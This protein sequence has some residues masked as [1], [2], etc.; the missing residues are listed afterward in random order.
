MRP[1]QYAL[2]IP[3]AALATH[4]AAQSAPATTEV[5]QSTFGV[6]SGDAPNMQFTPTTKISRA[7]KPNY[8]WVIQVKTDKPS[9]HWREE[10]TLPAAATWGVE[11]GPT[12]V[13]KDRRTAV[14][15]RDVAPSEG[16]I[17]NSWAVA[18]GDPAGHYVIKVSVDGGP[19][20]RFDFDVE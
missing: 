14:T 9:V 19:E 17:L 15:E 7:A 12:R 18:D 1:L 5:L 16:L 20:Q 8:G 6:F 4:A 13:S 3:I 10:F 2:L 11:G